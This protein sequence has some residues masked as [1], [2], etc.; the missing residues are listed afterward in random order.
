MALPFTVEEFFAVFARYNAAVW[1]AQAVA[2]AL[3]VA[4]FA[5][6]WRGG[7][8][9]GLPVAL[10]L[11]LFWATAGG[12]YHLGFFRAINPIASIAGAAFLVEAALL[13]IAGARGWLA[14]GRARGASAVVGAILAG[15]AAVL[16]PAINLAAGHALASSPAFGVTP[17]PVTI[18]TFGVFLLARPD[19]PTALLPIPFLWSLVGA[20][21][22]VRLGVPA[23]YGLGVA[24]VLGTALLVAGRRVATRVT[25]SRSA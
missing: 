22:A 2:Y 16:Y 13:A 10:T 6:A 17:C 18:F 14:F 23:D 1:P 4:A 24:G 3:G 25:P 20:S 5:A 12:V 9:S 15:Y 11:A 7:P 19:V 8:R 21:A